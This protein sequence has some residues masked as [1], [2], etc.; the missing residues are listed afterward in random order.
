MKL[1][2]EELINERKEKDRRQRLKYIFLLRILRE[3]TDE[4]HTLTREQITDMLEKE[5]VK[6]ERKTFYKDIE[7]LNDAGIEVQGIKGNYNLLTRDFELPELKLLVD[8][9][10][11]ARFISEKKSRDLI[12]KIGAMASMYEKEKLERQ[13]MINGRVKTADDTAMRN[14]DALHL[15]INQDCQVRFRYYQWTLE[16]KL[17]AKHN[18]AWYQVSPWLM[19]WDAENYYL[20]AYERSSDKIKHYRVDKM[21]Y[22]EALVGNEK[23]KIAPVKREGKELFEQSNPSKYGKRVFGM[24]GGDE[25]EVVLEAENKLASILIDRFGKDD[26]AIRPVDKDH[27][28]ARL[29]VV[30]SAIFLGWLISISEQ[31]DLRIISPE[32][33]AQKMLKLA[34]HTVDQQSQI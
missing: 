24:F 19:A 30:G 26:V 7:L 2:D 22:V 17:E 12:R 10:Q 1:N 15:A 16:K 14:L 11:S 9:V 21:K 31:S 34:Q 29:T 25:C 33:L 4:E 6:V 28:R 13:V 5:S 32:S 3:Y 8:A 18:G 20:I 27:F 23:K